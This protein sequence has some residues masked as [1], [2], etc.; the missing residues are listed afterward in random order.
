MLIREKGIV[1]SSEIADDVRMRAYRNLP[2]RAI[3]NL[4]L[5]AYCSRTK[6]GTASASRLRR[7]LRSFIREAAFYLFFEN[8][9]H[10][11]RRNLPRIE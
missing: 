5:N 11:S 6:N 4:I 2:E 8:L 9:K 7:R 1:L 3:S 10:E